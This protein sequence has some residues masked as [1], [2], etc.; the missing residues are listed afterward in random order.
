MRYVRLRWVL[1]GVLCLVLWPFILTAQGDWQIRQVQEHLKAA[2]F[3]PGPIDGILGPRTKATLRQYQAAHGLPV[4]GVLD[5]ATR[6]WLGVQTTQVPPRS[7]L[8]IYEDGQ[9]IEVKEWSFIYYYNSTTGVPSGYYRPSL[10]YK[11]TD[12]LLDLGER[13]EGKVRVRRERTIPATQLFIIRYHYGNR[14][15]DKFGEHAPLNKV[16]LTL[17]NGE[18]ITI[19]NFGASS[20]LI[21]GA[22]RDEGASPF[23]ISL[24]GRARSPSGQIG[25]FEQRIEESLGTRDSPADTVVELRF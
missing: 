10:R 25:E 18:I 16:T 21:K 1:V 24:S 7:V 8:V 12:L 2:G 13:T 6:K 20:K 17:V 4:T 22:T 23:G 15:K 11:S 9:Q 19:S 14:V 3:D 5:E